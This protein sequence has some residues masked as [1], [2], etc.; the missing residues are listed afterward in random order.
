[1]RK[2]LLLVAIVFSLG[3]IHAQ[4]VYIY[5]GK[6]FTNYDYKNAS[7]ASNP[8]LQAGVGT[9]YE[10]GYATPLRKGNITY[11]IGLSLNEYNAMGGSAANSYSWNT[12]YLG[13][14]NELSYSFFN[15][16][17]SNRNDFD[18]IV[19]GGLGLAT[20]IYGK[21][22]INGNFL[23]L[24]SQKEFSG[25]L[26]QPVVGLQVRYSVMENGYLSLGYNFS[27]SFNPTNNTN[28]KLSFNT[29]QL[30]FGIEFNIE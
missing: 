27:K 17:G 6:N 2:F 3:N 19:K 5:T 8:N 28:E 14:Q 10:I 20:L 1:M 12:Q 25:L 26:V 16:D 18:I 13:I 24:S 7:G 30:Q 29:H 23:D 9:F 15:S 11:A 22:E 4:E 21:Q